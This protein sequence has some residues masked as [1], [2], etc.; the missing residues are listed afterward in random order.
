MSKHMPLEGAAAVLQNYSHYALDDA[1]MVQ[2]THY[3][4]HEDHLP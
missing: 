2:T 4:Y 1:L 3:D